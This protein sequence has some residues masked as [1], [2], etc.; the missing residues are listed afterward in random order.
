MTLM[1]PPGRRAPGRS[2]GGVA[3]VLD[4]LGALVVGLLFGQSYPSPLEA[5]GG[6]DGGRGRDPALE[7]VGRPA[8]SELRIDVLFTG[9]GGAGGA[10]VVGTVSPSG[11]V[12]GWG[13]DGGPGAG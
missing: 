10:P 2:A 11:V 12:S 5:L 6:G 13:G 7:A 1:V 8:Q 4:R 9:L 3:A